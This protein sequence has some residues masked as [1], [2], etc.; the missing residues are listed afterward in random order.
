VSTQ[1]LFSREQEAVRTW[2]QAARGIRMV[3]DDGQSPGLL[4]FIDRLNLAVGDFGVAEFHDRTRARLTAAGIQPARAEVAAERR[5]T[6]N[7][8]G[9][10]KLAASQR[11]L[12]QFRDELALLVE[13]HGR[14]DNL[15]ARTEEV[16]NRVTEEMV[17]LDLSADDLTKLLGAMEP[18][19]EVLASGDVQRL[20]DFL[21]RQVSSLDQLRREPHR[22][23]S[24]NVP[25][26]KVV[27]WAVYFGCWVYEL[28]KC[29]IFG[30]TDVEAGIV[31]FLQA[32]GMVVGSLC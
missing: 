12:G 11:Y 15:A 28:F 29:T 1:L 7:G 6:Y 14:M 2:E 18:C 23:T 26:W 5:D 8:R 17:E 4:R 30:C 3:A 25:V 32:A 21:E 27:A 19:Y 13:Q 9:L 20:P 22:G 10:E 31:G 24:E 16:R